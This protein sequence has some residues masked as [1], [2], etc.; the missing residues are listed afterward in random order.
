ML[1]A[2]MSSILMYNITPILK[3]LLHQLSQLLYLRAHKKP[4]DE[5]LT[6]GILIIVKWF[7]ETVTQVHF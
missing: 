6:I 2:L 1:I 3:S 5:I 7:L 4:C